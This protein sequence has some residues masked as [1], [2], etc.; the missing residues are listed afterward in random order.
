MIPRLALNL[1]SNCLHFSAALGLVLLWQMHT[2]KPSEEIFLIQSIKSQKGQEESE[3]H[4]PSDLKMR[5]GVMVDLGKGVQSEPA[6]ITIGSCLPPGILNIRTFSVHSHR[7]NHLNANFMKKD[8]QKH[9]EQADPEVTEQGDRT[10]WPESPCPECLPQHF[11]YDCLFMKLPFLSRWRLAL[12]SWFCA[13]IPA[14]RSA[15]P[16]VSLCS[17]CVGTITQM[18]EV[19][20]GNVMLRV[21]FLYLATACL[22]AENVDLRF[23]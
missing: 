23:M 6:L 10:L 19:F 20:Q 9:Y 11:L 14:R 5:S 3:D 4:W 15:S 1:K 7:W 2:T 18:R 8:T 21:L 12:L 13:C 17:K 16:Y 22:K